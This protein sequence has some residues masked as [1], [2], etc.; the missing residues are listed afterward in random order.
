[1]PV[2]A[3]DLRWAEN[4]WATKEFEFIISTQS[5]VFAFDG[6]SVL[7]QKPIL[8]IVAKAIVELWSRTN[9][10]SS[11]NWMN[12][13]GVVILWLCCQRWQMHLKLFL[14]SEKG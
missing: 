3:G 11:Q 6:G 5:I 14:N 7:L 2:E 8:L 1:M 4:F 9:Q 12:M 10:K 13:E